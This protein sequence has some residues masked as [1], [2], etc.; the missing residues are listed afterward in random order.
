MFPLSTVGTLLVCPCGHGFRGNQFKPILRKPDTCKVEFIKPRNEG[1]ASPV[2]KGF[3]PESCKP[4]TFL[5][6]F[7]HSS[8]CSYPLLGASL[9]C[10]QGSSPGST[11]IP[12]QDA[13]GYMTTARKP[14]IQGGWVEKVAEDTQQ[15]RDISL[16]SISCP[17]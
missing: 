4:W 13:F 10:E 9:S 12:A 1:M 6:V 7:P 11:G 17:H 8:V 2:T 3:L 5:G 16:L 14:A 15:I